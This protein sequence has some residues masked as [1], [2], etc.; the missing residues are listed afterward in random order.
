MEGIQKDINELQ[1]QM[2]ELQLST[3][4]ETKI[5]VKTTEDETEYYFCIMINVNG[6]FEPALDEVNFDAATCYLSGLT[7]G[8][9]MAIANSF[10]KIH[11]N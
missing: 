6:E 10:R 11:S 7:I 8:H 5:V 2:L 9:E 3:G 4:I 1:Q